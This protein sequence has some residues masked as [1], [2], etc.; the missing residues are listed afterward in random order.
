MNYSL[1]LHYQAHQVTGSGA[2]KTQSCKLYVERMKSIRTIKKLFNEYS[3]IN[4]FSCRQCDVTE[5]RIEHCIL[6]MD[7]PVF[8]KFTLLVESNPQAA[9]RKFI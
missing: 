3:R 8:I 2:K 4:N 9:M 1:T 7:D 5:S 6:E